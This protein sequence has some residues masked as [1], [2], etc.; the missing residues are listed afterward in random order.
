MISFSYAFFTLM[1]EQ[2]PEVFVLAGK[3]VAAEE[4]EWHK[5]MDI[6]RAA[7]ADGY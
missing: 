1:A 7:Y 5:K 2:M 4:K 3:I 6:C